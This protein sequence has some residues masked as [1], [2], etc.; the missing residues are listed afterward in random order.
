MQV[1]YFPYNIHLKSFIFFIMCILGGEEMKELLTQYSS[2]YLLP[3]DESS[4]PEESWDDRQARIDHD[5]DIVRKDLLDS[6]LERSAFY[7]SPCNLCHHVQSKGFVKCQSCKYTLC[8]ECDKRHHYQQPFHNRWQ[9]N[10]EDMI[11]LGAM[12]FI[13]AVSA[14]QINPTVQPTMY[15]F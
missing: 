6:V 11:P 13:N 5:W 4:K 7:S 2:R 10:F 12:D 8:F 15:S 3:D 1:Q 14:Y 9:T